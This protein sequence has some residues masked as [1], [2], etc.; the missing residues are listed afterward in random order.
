MINLTQNEDWRHKF[1]LTVK[2]LLP[3]ITVNTINIVLPITNHAKR[4]PLLNYM[5]VNLDNNLSITFV[6]N[7]FGFSVR[8]L[9]RIFE[10]ELHSSYLQYLKLLRVIKAIELLTV[11]RKNVTETAYLVGYTSLA[12]FS[13]SFKEV[14]QIRPKIFSGYM[15]IQCI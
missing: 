2:H 12:A 10:Q 6:A 11:L 9:T 15:H 13:N 14:V 5:A 1:L 8:N 4:L 3:R 7:K